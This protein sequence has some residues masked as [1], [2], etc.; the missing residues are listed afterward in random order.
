[1]KLYRFLKFG[2][3][4]LFIIMHS[5]CENSKIKNELKGHEKAKMVLALDKTKLLISELAWNLDEPW[6]IT[7]GP[8]DHL[9][10]TEHKGL[11]KRLNPST[12]KIKEV[13]KVPDVYFA[14]TPGLLSMVLHPDFETEPFV[15]LHYTYVDS[16]ITEFDNYGRSSN[17]RSR[18]VRYRYFSEED[19]LKDKE[20][21]LP[22]IAGSGHHNGSRMAVTA[23]K[24]IIFA[25][26]DTG[27]RKGIHDKN[28]L[29]GKVLRLN[30][31]GS[32]P[33]DNPVKG[34]Y[35]Y[36]MGHRNP[37]G[38]IEARG[39]IYASEHGPNNDDEIN[40]I[41]PNTNYGWPYVEGYCNTE[42]ELTYCDTTAV[43]EPI[44]AWTPTI[45]P[46]GLDYYDHAAIPEWKNSLL[47]TTLK[48]RSLQLLTLDD[49]GENII[50]EKF[51]L[52]KQF[53]RF[54]DVCVSP[55]G[56]VYLITS[57][58][59]WH[60]NRHSWMYD[61]VPKEGNDRVIKLSPIKSDEFS[62][63]PEID[64]D[65]AQIRL[66]TQ[67]RINFSIPGTR[68]YI[69]NCAPCHLPSG[70]GIPNSV[71]PLVDTK[72]VNDRDKLIETTLNG[73]SGKVTIK[74]QEYEGVM[75]AFSVL[76][77]DEE[78][79]EILNYILINLND[80]TGSE[81]SQNEVSEIRKIRK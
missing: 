6:E 22:N 5:S 26:G 79:A 71:P 33:D 7:W 17:I 27:N 2:T 70:K 72:F 54:R 15:Y 58:S 32:V 1:M 56:D 45:A 29:V 68:A 51:Y 53:G 38:L 31:D 16:T 78:I 69:Q 49:E 55:S 46:A 11:V 80:H 30:L 9:W 52:Q 59:D 75:P 23:D 60:I 62:L 34:K 19:T 12:G 24:K 74:G 57:N 36:S 48:G 40:L 44:Y 81:I 76:L 77:N 8:D 18:I 65:S 25:I 3:L 64:G 61:N 39:K 66:F 28:T 42:N 41:R 73:L 63:L 21:I 47:L 37:Q 10:L 35:F 14:R 13:L 67:E 20:M 4:T 43:T 50:S